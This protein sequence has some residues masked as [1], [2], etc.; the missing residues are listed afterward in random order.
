MNNKVDKMICTKKY[1]VIIPAFN[2]EKKI[3]TTISGVINIV[4]DPQKIVVID[5]CSEDCTSEIVEKYNIVLLKHAENLGKGAALKTGFDFALKNNVHLVVTLD[6]DNQHDPSVIPLFFNESEFEKCDIVLG[7][8]EISTQVMSFDRY[9]SN[10]ITS[11]LI[12]L[13]LKYRIWDSQCGYRLVDLNIFKKIKLNSNHFE[14]ESEILIEYCKHG[15]R[16]N[17]IEIPTIYSDEISSINRTID[18]IRFFKMFI[19]KIWK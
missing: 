6:A 13:F 4:K 3:E 19:K 5:D 1:L 9:L 12:S 17:Q 10:Q 16:I 7:R 11:L 18:T 14:T 8:R 15:A 2:A